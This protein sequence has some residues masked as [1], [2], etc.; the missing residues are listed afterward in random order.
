MKTPVRHSTSGTETI[1]I[2][3]DFESEEEQEVEE[4]S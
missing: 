1:L 4:D 3:E 2:V